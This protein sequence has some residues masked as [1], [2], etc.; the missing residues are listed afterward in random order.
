M[1]GKEV[2][3]VGRITM[4]IIMVFA[5]FWV[6]QIA[7]FGGLFKYLQELL[8]FMVPPVTVLFLFGAFEGGW[9]RS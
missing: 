2:A 6:P 8:A 7:N 9:N 5:A 1:S 3:K 4:A